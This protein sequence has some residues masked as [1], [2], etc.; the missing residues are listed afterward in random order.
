MTAFHTDEYVDFL[1]KVTPETVEE[2]TISGQRC[3]F[4]MHIEAVQSLMVYSSS[5]WGWQPGIRRSVRVLLDLCWRFR[6][7]VFA[8]FT[9]SRAILLSSR[10]C[11]E[12]KWWSSRHRY[13]LGRRPS[14][15]QKTRG[16][17]IL[18]HQWH[19]TRH[20]G[21]LTD[22]SPRTLHWYWLSSWRWSRGGLLYH[23]PRLDL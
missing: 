7:W 5:D 1:H 12:S 15:R 19:R 21:T 4:A 16:I 8:L 17:R 3:A 2:L 11:A 6:R 9:W 18:L 23:G 13:Q 14:S 10:S 20:S 22:I